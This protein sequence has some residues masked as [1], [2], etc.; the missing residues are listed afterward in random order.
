MSYITGDL[1]SQPLSWD[2]GDFVADPFVCVEIKGEPCVVFLYHDLGGFLDGFRSYATLS[3][4]AE[5]SAVS[6]RAIH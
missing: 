4:G 2:C 1:V 6:G 3:G 5:S